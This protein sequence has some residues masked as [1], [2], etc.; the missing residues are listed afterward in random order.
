MVYNW[1]APDISK[2]SFLKYNKY[3]PRDGRKVKGIR[4]ILKK[5]SEKII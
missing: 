2:V 5:I 3:S 1:I 4:P